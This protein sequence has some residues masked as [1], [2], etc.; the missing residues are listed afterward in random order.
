MQSALW[1]VDLLPTRL[2]LMQSMLTTQTA[3]PNVFVVH[4]EAGCD[5]TGEFSAGYYMRWQNMNVT[6]SWQRD[7]TDCGRAPDYWSKNAIQWYCLTYEYQFSTNIGDC[8][9]W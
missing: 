3:T 5:R 1:S 9:N 2:E 6:A 7:V 8:V 4:C